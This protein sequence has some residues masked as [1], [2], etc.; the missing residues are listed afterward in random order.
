MHVCVYTC[1]C[2]SICDSHR[3]IFGSQ[4]SSSTIHGIQDHWV[5]VVNAWLTEPS[6]Q[7]STKDF[8]WKMENIW[9]FTGKKKFSRPCSHSHSLGSEQSLVFVSFRATQGAEAIFGFLCDP[10][11]L[12]GLCISLLGKG[13]EGDSVNEVGRVC[14]W[15]KERVSGF[16]LSMFGGV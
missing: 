6:H 16:P 14:R 7:P 2:F 4:F 9:P 11:L 10:H 12:D 1:I 15:V 13:L 8:W 5:Y 3:T